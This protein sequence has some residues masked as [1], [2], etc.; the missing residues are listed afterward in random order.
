MATLARNPL[1][2]PWPWFGGKSLVAARVRRALGNPPNY[3]EPFL[4]SA[5]VL[6]AR[7]GGAPQ[8]G[9]ET[10]NDLDGLLANAWRSIQLRPEETARH[11]DWPVN[12]VDL[13]AR[14]IWLV[15]NKADLTARLMGDPEW[16]DPKAAGWWIWGASSWIGQGWFSGKGPW[17]SV[18]GRLE[19]DSA[20]G[21]VSRQ[22]PAV[23]DKPGTGSGRGVSRAMPSHPTK[24]SDEVF[25][26]W[27]RLLSRRLRRVRL[28]CGDWTRV[29]T[30]TPLRVREPVG[31]FLDPS[32][33]HNSH[34]GETYGAANV[35]ADVRAW[36]VEN[37][38]NPALRIVLCGCAGE[39]DAL[40]ACGWRVE[41]W[42]SRGGYGSMSDGRGRDNSARERL[43]LSPGC[44]R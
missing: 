9:F 16:C 15:E 37:G 26:T 44:L 42:K 38:S 27:F 28:A 24:S 5:A 17:C 33:D 22:L 21:I 30:T 25:L 6:L 36:C 13:T 39:H 11:A 3:I 20:R 8:G 41:S 31:I 32:Y 23:G 19:R 4:G 43:W 40:E 10:V 7:P 34:S 14:H 18:G 2:C 1:R 12:E 35:S 29:L